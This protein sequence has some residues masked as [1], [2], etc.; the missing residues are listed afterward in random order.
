MLLWRHQAFESACD[1]I[2]IN[3]FRSHG[4]RGGEIEVL[5]ENGDNIIDGVPIDSQFWMFLS[6]HSAESRERGCFDIFWFKLAQHIIW[7]ASQEPF[8]TFSDH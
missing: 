3:D 5:N 8:N 7:Q 2:R 6:L 4:A 1:T